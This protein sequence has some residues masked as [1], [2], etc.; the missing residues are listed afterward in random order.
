MKILNFTFKN[1]AIWMMIFNL[2]GPWPRRADPLDD[3]PGAC[4]L[5]VPMRFFSASLILLTLTIFCIA[6]PA[7]KTTATPDVSVSPQIKVLSQP[8]APLRI[9]AQTSWAL[10]QNRSGVQIYIVVE[11][12]S[13]KVVRAYA[14]RRGAS[15]SGE[16]KACFPMNLLPGQVLQPGQ[17]DGRSTWQ[18]PWTPE[19]GQSVWVDFVE[20][21]DGSVWGADECH[22]ADQL[23][24]ERNGAREQ[25]EVLLKLLQ[26]GGPAAV[27]DF[28][29]ENFQSEAARAA[30]ERGE[31]PKIPVWPPPGH[32][33]VWEKGFLFGATTIVERV[34]A[35]NRE[36]GA[37]EI[38]AALRRPYDSSQSK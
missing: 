28:I 6:Q 20:L 9:S 5:I 14:T 34:L 11:N 17:K 22:V 33:K 15:A 32:S 25:R 3:L 2:A 16:P 36:W 4:T 24:G 31:K 35:A 21:A 23:N 19:S 13:G 27:L 30:L 37:Q 10:P 12:V 29:R 26:N 8:E 1:E 7:P 38:E 18:P